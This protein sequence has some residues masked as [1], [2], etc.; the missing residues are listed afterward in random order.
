MRFL[1]Q[2]KTQAKALQVNFPTDMQRVEDRL[3]PG[4]VNTR[5]FEL[6]NVKWPPE[7]IT[8][9]LLD[10]L[11]KRIVGQDSLFA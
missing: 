5:G 8:H 7:R 1:N 4:L 11:A 3:A 6:V 9:A 10:E 2:P